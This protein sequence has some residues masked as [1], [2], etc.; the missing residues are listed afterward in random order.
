M[1]ECTMAKL[2]NPFH[3]DTLP[4]FNGF[5][6]DTLRFLRELKKNNNREWFAEN[7]E[8]Y[9]SQVKEPML[10]LLASLASRMQ[11]RQPD[12]VLE[13]KNAMYRIYRDVRFSQDKSPYKVWIAAAFTYRGFD[14]KNDAAFYFHITPEEFGVGG[15]L[16]APP[17]DKLKNL[18]KAIDADPAPLRAILKDKSFRKYFGELEGEELSRVPQGYDK[19]HPDADLLKKKQFL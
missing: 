14:R 4:P 19:E 7:K 15:G 2:I 3:E 8:R 16:Y 6:K 9:E 13:P 10:M 18:R 5:P 1:S 11:V 17:G 12:V